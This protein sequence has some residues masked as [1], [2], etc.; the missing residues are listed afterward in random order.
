MG[1]ISFTYY[2][3]NMAN[4]RLLREPG[5]RLPYS[6]VRKSVVKEIEKLTNAGIARPFKSPWA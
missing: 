3:I 5:G 6:K 4:T 1:T 2:E